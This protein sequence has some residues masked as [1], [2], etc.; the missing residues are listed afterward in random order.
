MINHYLI[1]KKM[2]FVRKNIV[3]VHIKR[4][5]NIIYFRFIN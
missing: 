1:L 3:L 4:K 2:L 5:Q